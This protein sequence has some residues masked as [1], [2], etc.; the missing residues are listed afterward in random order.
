MSVRQLDEDRQRAK[1]FLAWATAQWEAYRDMHS[2]ETED[3][4]WERIAENINASLEEGEK[5]V[6]KSAFRNFLR[7]TDTD[8]KTITRKSCRNVSAGLG[9]PYNDVL[10][11]AGF[12]PDDFHR[13]RADIPIQTR[14]H[15]SMLPDAAQSV[16]HRCIE[17]L[18]AHMREE[19]K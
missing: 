16:V 9:I 19:G 10:L 6:Q 18:Y 11:Q 3:Q 5:R 1:D 8:T 15:Y 14:I 13:E 2:N 4:L 12:L 7:R 17:D